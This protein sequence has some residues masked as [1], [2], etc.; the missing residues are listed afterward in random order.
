METGQC[1]CFELNGEL[2]LVGT[3]DELV[4][5]LN[6]RL[7]INDMPAQC[8]TCGRPILQITH[9]FYEK[10]RAGADP[11]ETL[12]GLGL[13]FKH[14]CCRNVV[15]SRYHTNSRHKEVSSSQLATL[16]SDE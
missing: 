5:R 10:T 1:D 4:K 2:I 7:E 3:L 8:Y 6:T 9:S 11:H 15:L 14:M 16:A 12:L 13:D